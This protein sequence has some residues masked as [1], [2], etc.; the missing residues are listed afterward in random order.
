MSARPPAPEV[1][2]PA[3]LHAGRREGPAPERVLNVGCGN[4]TYG[5]HRIDFAP[6][7]AVTEVGSVLELPYKNGVFDEV[8]AGNVLEHMPNP[9]H[10]LQ[11]AVRV[12]G[13]GGRLVLV[14][15]HAGY[16][17]YYL[18]GLRYGDNH[19]WHG[20]HG[21][22]H[23]MLFSVG[24]L[25]NLCE[26]AGLE[27]VDVR[28]FTKWRQGWL[29]KLVGLFWRELACANVRVEARKPQRFSGPP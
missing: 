24:H 1:S 9:L 2:S 21:D 16:V 10:F 11:E 4:D 18:N 6:G 25:R 28:L 20:V 13:P 29:A 8:Y 26:A 3:M 19:R 14:T 5:T 15:D 27:V 12:L 22:R 17:G 23:F 7:S